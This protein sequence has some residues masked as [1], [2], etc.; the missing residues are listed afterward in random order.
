MTTKCMQSIFNTTSLKAQ[1]DVTAHRW[2]LAVTCY[3]AVIVT[4]NHL[5]NI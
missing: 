2:L 3:N 5:Q 4:V 1:A